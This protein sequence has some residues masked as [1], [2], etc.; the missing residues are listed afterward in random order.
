MNFGGTIFRCLTTTILPA[1]I[2]HSK[3]SPNS[4]RKE[5]FRQAKAMVI[6]MREFAEVKAFDD[7]FG[8]YHLPKARV[9]GKEVRN[10]G[11]IGNTA[12]ALWD[13][14]FSSGTASKV[15][16]E[17]PV[18][19][20]ASRQS[21]MGQLHQHRLLAGRKSTARNGLFPAG[22]IRQTGFCAR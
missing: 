3:P 2:S 16:G 4:P 21:R 15:S 7:A 13:E 11:T 19:Q 17:L 14:V 9:I 18:P 6:K 1:M 5:G 12:P 10:G 22:D 8:I 20:A